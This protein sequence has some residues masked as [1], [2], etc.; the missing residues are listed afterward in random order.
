MHDLGGEVVY[1]RGRVIFHRVRDA[2]SPRGRE[3]PSFLQAGMEEVRKTPG[4]PS[5]SMMHSPISKEDEGNVWLL[6]SLDERSLSVG[7]LN[8]R[9]DHGPLAASVANFQTQLVPSGE[10]V[11]LVAAFKC[12]NRCHF[13]CVLRKHLII[14]SKNW[15]PAGSSINNAIRYDRATLSPSLGLSPASR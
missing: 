6:H 9:V 14:T 2:I 15:S 11:K 5:S 10:K 7:D 4:L 13:Y 12:K 8:L 1:R 3:R